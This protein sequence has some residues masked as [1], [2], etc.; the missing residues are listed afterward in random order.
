MKAIPTVYVYY[1]QERYGLYNQPK[2]YNTV[3][4]ILRL[5]STMTQIDAHQ[6]S[7]T[8]VPMVTPQPRDK[9]NNLCMYVCET[10]KSK[11]CLASTGRRLRMF[12]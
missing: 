10:G 9:N 6:P 3:P 4:P 5:A 1:Q 11:T 7:V 2:A 8:C 12:G